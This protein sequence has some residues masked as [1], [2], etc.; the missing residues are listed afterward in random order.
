MDSIWQALVSQSPLAAGALLVVW[1]FL[2]GKIHTDGEFKR[3]EAE[4]DQYRQALD[5]ERKAVNETASAAAVTN[6]LIDGLVGLAEGK[7]ALQRREL[8]A[9][10]DLGL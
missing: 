9:A 2:S 7:P 10:K 3:V 8:P 6:K 4:R 1:L 5:T